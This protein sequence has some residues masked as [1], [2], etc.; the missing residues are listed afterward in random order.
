MRLIYAWQHPDIRESI[1]PDFL[2]IGAL[3]SFEETM[4]PCIILFAPL[5]RVICGKKIPPST[6]RTSLEETLPQSPVCPACID[7]IHK[8][9]IDASAAILAE[10]PG[11]DAT[12]LTAAVCSVP[13]HSP[14]QKLIQDLM[15]R[16]CSAADRIT[17]EGELNA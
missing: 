1:Y 13:A 11:M 3:P 4:C 14:T 15:P 17:L 2:H 7:A 6:R 9:I 8:Q 10:N 12:A 16:I 5:S